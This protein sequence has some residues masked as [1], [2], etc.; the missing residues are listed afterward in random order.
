M[1]WSYSLHRDMRRCQRS[2]AFRHVIASAVASD[3]LR[4]EAYIAKQ[5]TDVP[6]WRG[7]VVH[8]V[9]HEQF[10]PM[11]R[12]NGVDPRQFTARA[13]DLMDRQLAFSRARRYRDPGQTK[14]D[15]GDSYCAL[16]VHERGGDLSDREIDAARSDVR[17]AFEHLAGERWFLAHLRSAYGHAPETRLT[18]GMDG[19]TVRAD[20]DLLCTHE[21]GSVA[22]I[23]WKLA[24]SD[25]SE[26]SLQLGIY[27]LAVLRS[28]RFPLA[29]LD[30]I[31][32]WEANLLQGTFRLHPFDRARL[33]AVQDFIY[34]SV[35]EA[36]TLLDGIDGARPDLSE[37][38]VASRA[39]TCMHCP[40]AALCVADLRGSGRAREADVVEQ[41]T[42]WAVAS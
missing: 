1:R 4:R 27:G 23:D 21:P 28:G 34:R 39:E 32:L 12:G 31:E 30:G 9:L 20:P 6:A 11:L 33:E 41:R 26:Y 13:F 40:F 15:A 24:A 37:L 2:L 25:T 22:I 42:L 3:R 17:A 36:R 7:K 29:R 18:F 14:S 38:E 19:A 16:V 8:A 10:V 35:V 5:L